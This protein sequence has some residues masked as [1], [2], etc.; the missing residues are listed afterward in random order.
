MRLRAA[1]LD[2]LLTVQT[3]NAQA[4]RPVAQRR[5]GRTLQQDEVEHHERQ[6]NQA[7]RIDDEQPDAAERH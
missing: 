5:P 3:H 1:A 4:Q 7:Q 2:G 6:E